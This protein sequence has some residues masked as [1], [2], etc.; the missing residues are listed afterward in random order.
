MQKAKPFL[1]FNSMNSV[2]LSQNNFIINPEQISPLIKA[3]EDRIQ[4][5]EEEVYLC[6][7]FIQLINQLQMY[8]R[9]REMNKMA[10]IVD[11]LIEENKYLRDHIAFKNKYNL[12]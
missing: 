12:I 2:N 10:G 1:N 5:L 9:E 7:K 4:A 6:Y 8:A 3:S 11:L